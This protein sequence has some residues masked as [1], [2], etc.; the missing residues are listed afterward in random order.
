MKRI[1][2]D[3]D[4]T[5]TIDASAGYA[6]ATPNRAVIRKLQEYKAQGFEIVISTSR[7]MRT[8]AGNLG[9][10][11]V[12][13]LPTVLDWLRRHEVPCDEVYVAKP[14]CG[15]DGFYIDDRAVRP[16]EFVDLSYEQILELIQAKK[17]RDN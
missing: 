12:H 8:Y 10:I 6:D 4:H 16:S 1:V 17:N 13:T 9:K 5:L 14:W 7:N 3:L 2:V 15:K 11:N